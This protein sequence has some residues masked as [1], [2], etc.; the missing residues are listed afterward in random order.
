MWSTPSEHDWDAR[1]S[2]IWTEARTAQLN[3]QAFVRLPAV[4]DARECRALRE[5]Y[6]HAD[7]FRKT[8][9]ME[10]H[11]FG[12]GEYR[13]FRAPLP[14]LVAGL[15]SALY[16][17]LAPTANLFCEQLGSEQ[18]YPADLA[19]CLAQSHALGQSLP[20]PL[21]LR[22]GPGD[23]NCLHQDLYGE[24]WFPLQVALLLDQPGSDFTGG[25]F[26]LV[27]QRPRMQSR[28]CVVSLEQGDAVVFAT[29]HRPRRGARGFH[30]TVLRH[31]VSEVHRGE[32]HVLGLIF[33]DA[34]T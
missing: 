17:R 24:F 5:L 28:P 34:A 3:E 16:R 15:R 9:V 33:H 31:G 30:R 8:V 25:E 7:L 20:T 14:E 10:R 21:L 32:R 2:P 11:G 6:S 4:L 29:N 23:Y 26:V 13:Y 27:E 19:Q 12:R 1:L 22:Y 18:R